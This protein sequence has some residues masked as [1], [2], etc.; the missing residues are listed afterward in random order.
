M[1]RVLGID[2]PR[3][4]IAELAL[5]FH[6]A[7]ENGIA[8]RLGRAIDRNHNEL[9]LAPHERLPILLMLESEPIPGLEHLRPLLM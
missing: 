1:I 5:R 6:H 8:T 4:A 3:G 7:G 9:L 2:V